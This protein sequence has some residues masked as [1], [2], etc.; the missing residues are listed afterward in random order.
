MNSLGTAA[1]SRR[2][3]RRAKRKDALSRQCSLHLVDE[4]LIRFPTLRGVIRARSTT[5]G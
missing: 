3:A 5:S 1:D 2:L 4:R